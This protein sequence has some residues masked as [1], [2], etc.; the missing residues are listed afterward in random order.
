MSGMLRGEKSLSGKPAI[1]DVPVGQGHVILFG[2]RPF[3]R[4]ETHG[5]HSLVFN[6]MLHWN[7][8]RTGWP[9]RPSQGE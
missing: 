9:E 8:L 5:S 4:W 6:T 7:D 3:W 1:V 2:N